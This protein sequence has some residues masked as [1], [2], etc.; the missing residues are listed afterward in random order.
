[1]FYSEANHSNVKKLYDI[2][3]TYCMYNFD[4]GKYNNYISR[5]SSTPLACVAGISKWRER[6]NK[7]GFTLLIS[8]SPSH[9]KVSFCFLF[10]FLCKAKWLPKNSYNRAKSKDFRVATPNVSLLSGHHG[11]GIADE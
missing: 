6:E 3:L 10:G 5:Q 7:K 11:K 2:L 4:L 8:Y 9:L 1:V